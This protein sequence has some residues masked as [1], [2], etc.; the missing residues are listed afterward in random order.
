M[1]KQDIDFEVYHALYEKPV[2]KKPSSFY[3]HWCVFK[4]CGLK[5]LINNWA[6]SVCASVI[7]KTWQKDKDFSSIP[8][9]FKY[10]SKLEAV[11]RPKRKD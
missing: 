10:I 5:G 8:W 1:K 4:K 7:H 9:W 2:Y 11:T 6:D 3:V